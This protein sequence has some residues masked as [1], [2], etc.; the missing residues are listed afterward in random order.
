[1]KKN[2]MLYL[3]T[4]SLF[5]V[6]FS[7][8][9]KDDIEVV[10]SGTSV[11]YDD[12]DFDRTIT[13]IFSSSG[14]A[15]VS[16]QGD[17]QTV[18][19]SGNGVTVTNTGSEMITYS[20]SG[21]TSNGF[22]KV[23]SASAQAIKLNG[24]SVT[25]TS[26]AAINIQG[27][28]ESLSSGAV[29]YVVLEGTNTLGDGSTYS[30]TPDDEDEKG[31]IFAEGPLVFSGDGSLTVKAVG[32]S[33]I[34][35]DDDVT[36]NGGTITVTST[37]KV[38]VTN[39]DTTKV[40]GVK[41]KDGF[42][43]NDG[44]L[45]V[46]CSGTGARGMSSDGTAT[47]NGGTINITVTGS[48]F[49]SSSGNG[50]NHGGPGGNSSSSDNSVAAKGMKFDGNITVT[51]GTL[52]VN[53]S[54]HEA[55]ESKGEIN[56]SGGHIYSHSAGDDAINSS[57]NLT[58]DDGYVCAYSSANDGIDANGNLYINGGVVYAI[59]SSSPELA[60]DANTEGGYKLYVNGG[61]LIAIGGL[62]SGSSLSQS[63]YST[64]SWSSSTWYS[65][66]VGNTVY[67][68]KT[69][70]SAGSSLIVSASSTPTLKSG[71]SASGGTEY[72]NGMLLVG[73]SV[74]GGNSVSLSSYNGGNSGGG[75][76]GH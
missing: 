40:A 51:G 28:A 76:G 41:A 69:P 54:N 8:C 29:T 33:G 45:T 58:I 38:F 14:N 3:L 63:C 46:T 20:L 30:N 7:S 71:V 17:D 37:A 73:A 57:S 67:A 68:F 26:G 74:S 25:N 18:S 35:S 36:I 60:I 48:N 1:M 61:T 52:I 10:E 16:G 4:M 2:R 72:F 34:M 53:C 22:L 11:S 64:S 19:I 39:G 59:G 31:A 66:T 42:V 21:S 65:M 47:I 12:V 13:V 55:I 49:G 9:G 5:L 50:G 23:Y 32:K 15:T 43:M 56:V 24:V 62:E 27:S 6:I 70:S 75:P 44:N